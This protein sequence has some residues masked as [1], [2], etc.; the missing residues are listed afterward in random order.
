MHGTEQQLAAGTAGT[1]FIPH[2]LLQRSSSSSGGSGLASD[3]VLAQVSDE[4]RAQLRRLT[5]SSGSKISLDAVSE[6]YVGGFKEGYEAGRAAAVGQLGT[7]AVAAAALAGGVT[8]AGGDED[9]DAAMDQR[10]RVGKRVVSESG[11]VQG[12]QK[13]QSP[14]RPE[15]GPGGMM[16]PGREGVSGHV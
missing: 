4:T 14:E 9:A 1:V 7:A 5:V 16:P 13:Q 6:A 10:V 15:P 3:Y 11:Q 12:R 2:N 8:A